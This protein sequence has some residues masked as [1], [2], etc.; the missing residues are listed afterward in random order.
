[1]PSLRSTT[2]LPRHAPPSLSLGSLGVISRLLKIKKIAAIQLLLGVLT[3]GIVG[4]R[5]SERT[6]S[7]SSTFTL[8]PQ[9]TE[10][11]EHS[12]RVVV[13]LESDEQRRPLLRAT[14]TPLE[15]GF[16]LYG[17]DL[18]MTG[19]QGVGLPTRLDIP[20]QSSIRPA[21]PSFAD[22]APHDLRF[23]VLDITL[24]IYPEGPVTLHFPVELSPGQ[25]AVT[26]QLVSTCISSCR[27]KNAGCPNPRPRSSSA[28][29]SASN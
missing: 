19:V 28:M 23:D 4:C 1:M 7:P 15:A 21:G 27:N 10:F 20:K 29:T 3:F 17:K 11:T 24:P 9:L 2:Q 14:F 13:S 16:H 12:V 26:A 18:P 5:P 22:V 8:G 25:R 6:Y